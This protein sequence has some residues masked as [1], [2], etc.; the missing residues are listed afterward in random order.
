MSTTNENDFEIIDEA[1]L[2]YIQKHAKPSVQ[3]AQVRAFAL[4]MME[5]N[6]MK[7][8]LGRLWRAVNVFRCTTTSGQVLYWTEDTARAVA[9]SG[10]QPDMPPGREVPVIAQ[11]PFTGKAAGQTEGYAQHAENIPEPIRAPRKIMRGVLVPSSETATLPMRPLSTGRPGNIR[12]SGITHKVATVLFKYR[13]VRL[14]I[15]GATALCVGVS[16]VDVSRVLSQLST[17]VPG[18]D[19]FIKHRGETR[20]DTNF[21]WNTAYRYPHAAR[22][23]EDGQWVPLMNT[24]EVEDTQPLDHLPPEELAEEEV[25]SEIAKLIGSVIGDVVEPTTEPED[26]TVKYEGDVEEE[27]SQPFTA[28]LPF[29]LPEPAERIKEE[30]VV[31]KP[32]MGVDVDQR[33]HPRSTLVT[34]HDED[35]RAGIFSDG[36][37]VLNFANTV[38]QLSPQQTETL[39][40]LLGPQYLAR[41]AA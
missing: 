11:A 20:F 32:I 21:Q 31:S 19:Y 9:A 23:P 37:M 18:K 1:L 41:K 29:P 30:T 13:D 28:I 6:E 17:D 40:N 25:E 34:S 26:T 39:M 35:F 22:Q 12:R 27:E 33:R 5:E 14:S 2:S 38:C 24:E 7:M 8:S 16:R 10:I 3:L 36:S 4:T 15:D